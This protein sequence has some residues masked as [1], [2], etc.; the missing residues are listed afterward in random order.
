MN[1]TDADNILFLWGTWVRAHSDL[2]FG[3]EN[4]IGR[5]I[6]Q[7]P[8]AGQ[9]DS[10]QV[11]DMPVEVEI[12]ERIVLKMEDID[13]RVVKAKYI[14]RFEDNVAAK[15]CK[16]HVDDY[17]RRLGKSISFTAGCLAMVD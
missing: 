12:A 11:E 9:V 14:G 3:R 5:M 1:E 17:L 7:G 4:T 15:K 8:G 10:G 16:C 6:R 13:Q 2:G